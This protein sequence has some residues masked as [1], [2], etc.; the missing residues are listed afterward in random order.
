M[1]RR[2]PLLAALATLVLAGGGLVSSAHSIPLEAP[3]N[4]QVVEATVTTITLAWDAPSTAYPDVEVFV[5]GPEPG[6]TTRAHSTWVGDVTET[7]VTGLVCGSDY[8]VNVAFSDGAYTFPGPYTTVQA[9]TAPCTKPAPDPPTGLQLTSLGA[10]KLAYA[11][12]LPP[13]GIVAVHRSVV[14][15]GRRVGGGIAPTNSY[16]TPILVCEETYTFSLFFVNDEGLS[17]PTLQRTQQTGNCLDLG[18]RPPAPANFKKSATRD[19][20]LFEWSRSLPQASIWL[21]RITFSA[22]GTTTYHDGAVTRY[23]MPRASCSTDYGLNVAFVDVDGRVSE[24]AAGDVRTLDCP[25]PPAA[26]APEQAVLGVQQK[27]TPKA[28]KKKPVI[29]LSRRVRVNKFRLGRLRLRCRTTRPRCAGQLKL[30]RAKK[31]VRRTAL[32]VSFGKK[33]YRAGTKTIKLHVRLPKKAFRALKRLKKVTVFATVTARDRAGD[34]S[35][36]RVRVTLLA[37]KKPR[38]RR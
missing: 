16:T 11:W 17:S 38:R 13:A 36:K 20:L 5:S 30:A 35:R 26:A 24:S 15:P 31:K 23:D 22:E 4:V 12:D 28:A 33:R 34:T 25:V 8:V 14:G 37:P 6:G 32:P 27:S 1:S 3:Q 19:S 21:T 10:N 18:D 7:V 2:I 9:S 29:A